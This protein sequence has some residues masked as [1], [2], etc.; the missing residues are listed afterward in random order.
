MNEMPTFLE[1]MQRLDS[2]LPPITDYNPDDYQTTYNPNPPPG[3]WLEQMSCIRTTPVLYNL[4]GAIGEYPSSNWGGTSKILSSIDD[5][6]R[7]PPMSER[8][9]VTKIFTSELSALKA[10]AADQ[11][12][13]IKQFET[14]F[15]DSLADTGRGRGELTEQQI[16]ALGAITSARSAL[17]SN[18]KEQ[19][20]IKK[21]VAELRIKQQQNKGGTGSGTEGN[22]SGPRD[23]ASIGLSMMDSLFE[24]GVRNA[25]PI[26]F[27][28]NLNAGDVDNIL[29]NAV[30][31][32]SSSI[33]FES[34]KPTTYVLVGNTDDDVEYITM[35]SDGEIIHNYDNPT[36]MIATVDRQT[37]QA[38]DD[39][40]NAYPVIFKSEM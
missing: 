21:N 38:T 4:D 15:R 22:A 14:L 32:I 9:D 33:A 24:S 35:D 7:L 17:T 12:R 3:D 2:V 19:I 26:A 18:T 20:A 25:A 8:I 37:K 10:S 6:S 34:R 30:P 1:T 23:A 39:L 28:S 13:I 27:S 31:E 11:I 36:A 40:R 16:M 5:I 29:D